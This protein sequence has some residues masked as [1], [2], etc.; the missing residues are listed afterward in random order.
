ML[1]SEIRVLVKSLPNTADGIAE[2]MRKENIVGLVGSA[3][4]CPLANYFVRWLP[5]VD[6]VTVFTRVSALKGSKFKSVRSTKAMQK[7][8]DKFDKGCYPDL[9]LRVPENASQIFTDVLSQ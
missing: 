9:M 7:F 6:E 3:T 1:R 5:E 8:I 2:L 4:G